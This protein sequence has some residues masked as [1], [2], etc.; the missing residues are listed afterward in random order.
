MVITIGHKR[1][2][3]ALAGKLDLGPA[4]TV[5]AFTLFLSY[6]SSMAYNHLYAEREFTML[7]DFGVHYLSS[8]RGATNLSNDAKACA[9]VMTIQWLLSVAYFLVFCIFL[10]PFSKFV[11]V[12]V[13]KATRN[14]RATQ[15]EDRSGF[16]RIVF[17]ILVPIVFLADVRLIPIPTF[18]NGG[19]FAVKGGEAPL[20]YLIN[21]SVFM[22]AF[23]W[24]VVFATF[25]FYWSWIHMVA[26]YRAIF[27]I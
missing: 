14:A 5:M 4:Y 22:P 7:S 16:G 15:D 26:N 19:L 8:V 23:S 6:A 9:F 12:A 3:L 17:L 18:F 2:R 11:K 10:S 25:L 20:V 13:D 1:R 24:L 27:D 21:S